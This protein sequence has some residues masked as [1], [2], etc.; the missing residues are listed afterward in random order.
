[1]RLPAKSDGSI[2]TK[3]YFYVSLVYESY[4]VHET[5]RT[6][7]HEKKLYTTTKCENRKL[8]SLQVFNF[9]SLFNESML[10]KV[11]DLENIQMIRRSYS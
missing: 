8:W 6:V 10:S 11:V 7:V 5:L 1:M 4:S 2:I 3:A 9:L